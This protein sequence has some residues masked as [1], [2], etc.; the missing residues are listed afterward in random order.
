MLCL[1]LG[2]WSGFRRKTELA[3]SF[4]QP[5]FTMLS[6][7]NAFTKYRY[8]EHT[9]LQATDDAALDRAWHDWIEQES[10]K[11]LVLH[12]F[13]YDSQ[14]CMVHLRNPLVSSAQML[15]P[16]PASLRMWRADAATWRELYVSKSPPSQSALPSIIDIFGDLTL[17]DGLEDVADRRLCCLAACHAAAHEVWYFRQQAQLLQHHNKQ[18]KRDRRLAHT[19]RQREL[20][21]DLSALKMYCDFQQGEWPEIALTLEFLTMLLFVSVDDIQLFSGRAGEE[22]ARKVYPRIREWTENSEARTAVY[23]AGQVFRLASTFEKSKLRDFY[24]VVVYHSALL[25]WVYGLNSANTARKSRAQTP[26]GERTPTVAEPFSPAKRT[27]IYVDGDDYKACQAFQVLGRGLPGLNAGNSSAPLFCSLHNSKGVMEIAVKI[28]RS[29]FPN[30]RNG[31]P[32]LVENLANLMSELG[33]F[34]G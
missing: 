23:H 32:P 6:W 18:N 10:L 19:S 16:L 9:P 22:E 14:V 1:D 31:L 17:L 13:I 28:L 8:C 27:L 24:A 30:S 15:L 12:T 33:N 26:T 20:L 2:T 11:R 3:N 4:L 21:D 29:N 5:I 34:S 7:S 25:L